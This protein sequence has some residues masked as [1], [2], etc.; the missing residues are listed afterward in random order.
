MVNLSYIDLTA[1]TKEI[2]TVTISYEEYEVAC[3]NQYCGLIQITDEEFL[4]VV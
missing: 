1:D 3:D 2:A 4:D